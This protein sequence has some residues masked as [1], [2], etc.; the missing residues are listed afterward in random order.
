MVKSIIEK[1]MVFSLCWLPIPK[2]VKKQPSRYREGRKF[3]NLP[4]SYLF[5][6]WLPF[7][8]QQ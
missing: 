4:K 1:F 8:T 3:T 6:A 5:A 2:T 7:K